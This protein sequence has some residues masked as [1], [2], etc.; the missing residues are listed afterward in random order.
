MQ[1]FKLKQADNL[2]FG[3]S[4]RDER[5]KQILLAMVGPILFALL[6]HLKREVVNDLGGLDKIKLR[7]L[8]RNHKSGFGDCGISFEYS[9]H[10]AIRNNNPLVMERIQYA[11]KM[12]K[13]S[14][15][16]TTSILLGFE[17]Q[18]VL[19]ISDHWINN[20]NSESEVITGAYGESTR[21]YD[22][23]YDIR[24]AFHNKKIRDNIP[25]VI[26]GIWRADLFI[27]NTDSNMWVATSVKINRQLLQYDNGLYL[28]IVA[29][30]GGRDIPFFRKDGMLVCP[31]PLGNG[32]MQYF[33]T[34]WRI[35]EEFI[36]KDAGLPEVRHLYRPADRQVAKFLFS[37]RDENVLDLV[38]DDL[39]KLAHPTLVESVTP[40]VTIL[41]VLG[42]PINSDTG[43]TLVVPDSI[44]YP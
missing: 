26:R 31:L 14:G 37:K 12:C 17:K 22:Y 39:K 25:P 33:Y 41:D 11:L 23:R 18:G 42:N 21:I 43:L 32:F 29:A 2:G 10:S 6:C 5:E 8:A 30:T 24:N 36:R 3:Y 16:Q 1:V 4:N 44:I 9:V 35:V 28:G 15:N 38:D 13:I 20:M 7:Q 40:D 27:G 34:A 19:Q